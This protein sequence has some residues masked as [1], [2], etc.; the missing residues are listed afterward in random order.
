MDADERPKLEAD[1]PTNVYLINKL[2]RGKASLA[3][4]YDALFRPHVHVELATNCIL[5]LD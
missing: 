3:C 5:N 2:A 1:S 4:E